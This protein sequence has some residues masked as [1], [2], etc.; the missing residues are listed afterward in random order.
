MFEI[1]IRQRA[2]ITLDID[3]QIG[4]G[5]LHALVG[6]SGSGKTTCL[7]TIAGLFRPTSGR[8]RGGGRLWFDGANFVPAYRRP[9]GF[10]FQSYALFPHMNAV[11]NVMMAMGGVV[12]RDR[13]DRALGLLE[14]VHLK[15]LEG[16]LPAQLSGGQQQR[17]A[18]ARALARDPEI[19][20]L[21][22]PF[23]AVD[24]R[25]RQRLYRE[26][27]LLRAELAIPI[28][29]VTHDLDE[30]RMLADRMT[31]LYRGRSLATATPDELTNRP[32]SVTAARLL[33]QRNIF[34]AQV[35][36]R[37]SIKWAG[38]QLD[39]VDSSAFAKGERIAW[40]IPPASVLV[41]R[42]D[43]PSR[44]ERENPV[45]G[46][47][48]ETVVLGDQLHCQLQLASGERIAFTISRHAARRNDIAKD[49]P[50]TVSLLADGIHLMPREPD[51]TAKPDR[52]V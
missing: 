6:P 12:R 3:F 5:E 19:L 8:I 11:E 46:K 2:P 44:G 20:L 9:V 45:S 1:A 27:A 33:G 47:I 24:Q 51:S 22:E 36:G 28:L 37:H 4:A 23:A 10:V 49:L 52:Y 43:R 32:P 15:G 30:A 13:R 26:L 21:D 42:R 17:V 38:H 29:L 18:M 35:S 25:T 48:A 14:R 31:I 41:H 34:E 40:L 39:I 16:R 7:R 50:A